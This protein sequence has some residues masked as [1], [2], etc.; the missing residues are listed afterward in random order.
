MTQE[1]AATAT[2]KLPLTSN[3]DDTAIATF[4]IGSTIPSITIDFSM[5]SAVDVLTTT[6]ATANRS[7]LMGPRYDVSRM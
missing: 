6:T 3:V 2:I 7:K 1:G 5:T 4:I